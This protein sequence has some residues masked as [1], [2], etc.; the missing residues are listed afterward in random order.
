M[1]EEGYIVV[2]GGCGFIGS[3][4]ILELNKKGIENIVIVDNL[5]EDIKLKNIRNCKFYDL[6]NYK[7]GIERVLKELHKLDISYFFHIGAI[8]NVLIKD[9]DFMLYYNFKYSKEYLQLALSKGVPFIYASSSAVYG[10]SDFCIPIPQYEKPLNPYAYSKLLFDNYVRNLL[11]LQKINTK[12]IGFRF[13]NV[14]GLGEFHKEQ[15]A[16]IPYRFYSFMKTNKFIEL[17]EG[18]EK[19]KRDYIMVNDVVKI[20]IFSM[21]CK[22]DNGIYNLGSGNTL[23]HREVADI[24]LEALLKNKIIKG[25]KTKYIKSIPFPTELKNIFQFFTRAENLS[26]WIKTQNIT[27]PN[28]GIRKY[29]EQLISMEDQKLL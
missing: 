18:G 26:S 1:K 11:K 22:I 28:V 27:N 12:L 24:I 25:N 16:S 15:N 10:N 19:I 6:I 17:F 14:Y 13:F 5:N 9:L 2:T 21:K 3:N 23:S 7:N 4:L 8:T 20:L 29:I